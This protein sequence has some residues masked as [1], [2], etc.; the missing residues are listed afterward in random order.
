MPLAA[1]AGTDRALWERFSTTRLLDKFT[2]CVPLSPRHLTGRT[3]LAETQYLMSV[4]ALITRRQGRAFS[5]TS[6]LVTICAAM[7]ASSSL[8]LPLL[9]SGII[10]AVLARARSF[11]LFSPSEI[12][13]CRR[14]LRRL[15]LHARPTFDIMLCTLELRR[16]LLS[17]LRGFSQHF[18]VV[19][20]LLPQISQRGTALAV[21]A[22]LVPYVAFSS[23]E[24]LRNNVRCSSKRR[25]VATSHVSLSSA[26]VLMAA[27]TFWSSGATIDDSSTPTANDSSTVVFILRSWSMMSA[28]R[29]TCS[30]KLSLVRSNFIENSKPILLILDAVV[31]E[32]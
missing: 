26:R 24:S 1:R 18:S 20:P 32:L 23:S 5:S 11:E 4:P 28:I 15:R 27:V 31:L 17:G 19:W 29:S 14:R 25:S 12:F 16:S 9:T 8:L 2:R 30:S 3:S 10:L 21:Y 13:F 7:V 6:V 22:R